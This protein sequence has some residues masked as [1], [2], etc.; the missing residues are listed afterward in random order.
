MIRPVVHTRMVHGRHD[1]RDL[2]PLTVI[3]HLY[4]AAC[5]TNL[6][7]RFFTI[8]IFGPLTLAMPPESNRW[9]RGRAARA[10]SRVTRVALRMTL[11]LQEEPFS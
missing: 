3:V 7:V 6:R 11:L 2:D 1:A 4:C 10:L 9:S 5:L 8:R